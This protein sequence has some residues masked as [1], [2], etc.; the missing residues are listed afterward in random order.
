MG[1]ALITMQGS[2]GATVPPPPPPLSPPPG[3][4]FHVKNVND[5]GFIFPLLKYIG[6]PIF[7]YWIFWILNISEDLRLSFYVSSGAKEETNYQL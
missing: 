2:F 4:I 1:W 7:E 5:V 6:F 3:V